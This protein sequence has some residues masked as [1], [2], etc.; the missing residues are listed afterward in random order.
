MAKKLGELYAVRKDSFVLKN[1]LG[2]GVDCNKRWQQRTGIYSS[3]FSNAGLRSSS[4]SGIRPC[5]APAVGNRSSGVR[6]SSSRPTSAG[7]STGVPKTLGV[8]MC[9][10]CGCRSFFNADGAQLQP[11]PGCGQAFYC[12]DACREFDYP[13]HKAE[14][15]FRS[16]GRWH[17]AGIRPSEDCWVMNPAMTAARRLLQQQHKHLSSSTC[18]RPGT[19]HAAS[20][21]RNEPGKNS[22]NKVRRCRSAQPGSRNR[23]C[24]EGFTGQP[25]GCYQ[26]EEAEHDW[27]RQLQQQLEA[28]RLQEQREVAA[29][30]QVELRASQGLDGPRPCLCSNG[31]EKLAGRGPAAAVRKTGSS[32]GG[33]CGRLSWSAVGRSSSGSAQRSSKAWKGV[34]EA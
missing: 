14:C 24:A 19:A 10:G 3:S 5:T 34:H 22:S 31:K 1:H 33:V 32:S 30:Q 28:V 29:Q 27:Q 4:G 17:A 20:A 25:S 26:Q 11:C 12:S 15:R 9:A 6:S 13:S 8:A 2:K 7:G 18:S 23:L 21:Q 16:T